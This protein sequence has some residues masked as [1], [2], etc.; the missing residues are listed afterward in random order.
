MAVNNMATQGTRSSVVMVLTGYHDS[1]EVLSPWLNILAEIIW[2]HVAP[3][4]N[5][6]QL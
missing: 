4:T 1:I 5:T 3:F 2:T 6:D